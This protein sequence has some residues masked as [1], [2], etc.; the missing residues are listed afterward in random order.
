MEA[1]RQSPSIAAHSGP[2]PLVTAMQMADFARQQGS[3]LPRPAALGDITN[4]V[5]PGV[6]AAHERWPGL[7]AEF[8]DDRFPLPHQAVRREQS[9][10]REVVIEEH[11]E[12]QVTTLPAWAAPVAVPAPA[13]APFLSAVA[14][15]AATAAA[16]E[17][18]NVTMQ[19][20]AAVPTAAPAAVS[21]AQP[22]PMDVDRPEAQAAVDPHPQHVSEY[23]KDIYTLLYMG[24]ERSLPRHDYME[25]QRDIN[26]KMRAILVDWLVEVHLK[27]RL[28]PETLFLTVNL[29]DRYLSRATVER[30]RLQLVGVVAMFIAAKFEEIHPP[31]VGD[32]VYISDNAYTKE[33]VLQ[34]ECS[35]LTVL[36]FNICCPTVAHFLERLVRAN[37]CDEVHRRTAQY[38]SELALLD[39]RLVRFPPSHIAAAALLLSNELLGRSPPWPA[40]MAL[41]AR[42]EEHELRECANEMLNLLRQAP[43]SPYHAVRKKFSSRQFHSVANLLR[44]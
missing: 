10:G 25:G 29:I 42:K 40:A 35:M 19:A 9:R 3:L 24:E 28:Q 18:R 11:P 6:R 37:E 39:I 5:G 44:V 14:Q 20:T 8:C 7:A 33:E 36:A 23:A 41:Y 22:V 31:E 34:M 15:A 43:Y 13:P 2:A 30:R 26:G 17:V 32:F 1:A 27:Y 16:A 21:S 38:A 4:I 12:R